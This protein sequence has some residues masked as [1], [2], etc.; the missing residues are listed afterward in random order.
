[1]W[2]TSHFVFILEWSVKNPENVRGENV[3]KV[4][5]WLEFQAGEWGNRNETQWDQ[6]RDGWLGTGSSIL[7]ESH[8]EENVQDFPHSL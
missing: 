8:V 2:K 3:D 1:M 6:V 7:G 5:N 4:E